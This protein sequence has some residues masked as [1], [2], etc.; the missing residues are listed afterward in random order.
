[1]TNA[2]SLSMSRVEESIFFKFLKSFFFSQFQ[3]AQVAN[4]R[5]LLM[6]YLMTL[7]KVKWLLHCW[8]V[9]VYWSKLHLMYLDVSV[10]CY[11]YEEVSTAYELVSHQR[12]NCLKTA[13][14]TIQCQW[15]RSSSAALTSTTC[16]S[17]WSSTKDF[18]QR[19]TG[20]GSS[21]R[22]TE[23]ENQHR[24]RI[25]VSTDVRE[26]RKRSSKKSGLRTTFLLDCAMINGASAN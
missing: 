9:S 1:M 24:V 26:R 7:K 12:W 20:Q 5:K 15:T 13:E 2:F 25:I 23:I 19:W 11:W 21:L 18:Q 6:T 22:G 14:A 4:P 17:C 3:I 10:Y 8:E 16:W